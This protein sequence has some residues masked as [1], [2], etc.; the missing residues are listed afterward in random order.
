MCQREFGPGTEYG[1]LDDNP[2]GARK[3]EL[4][5]STLL[6]ACLTPSLWT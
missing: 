5:G 3:A 4:R 6:K 2:P 1:R